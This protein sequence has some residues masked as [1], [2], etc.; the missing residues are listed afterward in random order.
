MDTPLSS[1]PSVAS[2]QGDPARRVTVVLP[3]NLQEL[4]SYAHRHFGSGASR[5]L[6]HG[7]KHL[8]LP[9]HIRHVKGGDVIVVTKDGMLDVEYDPTTL[10]THREHYVRH[11]LPERLPATP[12][13]HR[14]TPLRF[15]G[16][17]SYVADYIEHPVGASWNGPPREALR[18]SKKREGL[19]TGDSMYSTQYP[20]HNASPAK[21]MRRNDFKS[22]APFEGK[23]SYSADYV[24]HPDVLSSSAM[25]TP[26]GTGQPQYQS[27]PF[28]G[29]T[30]Y[31]KDF[32]TP[33]RQTLS[34][35][36]PRARQKTPLP[37]EGNTEYAREFVQVEDPR[38]FVHLEPEHFHS[39]RRP[40][41]EPM[42]SRAHR[43]V[44]LEPERA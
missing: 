38:Q 24:S 36:P 3:E 7:K 2:A 27:Q 41:S 21:P 35:E 26:R 10:T 18:R 4:Q 33:E 15:D 16:K 5:L 40:Q 29:V 13:T 17:S 34:R 32:R 6:H 8:R 14:G 25:L 28:T 31:L 23:S 44:H 1:N 30:T 22:S 19:K 12:L 11:P 42:R 20:W 39:A 43:V 9:H 37:F